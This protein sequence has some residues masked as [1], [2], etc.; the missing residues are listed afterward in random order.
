MAKTIIAYIHLDSLSPGLTGAD[1]SKTTLFV[2]CA[3][4]GQNNNKTTCQGLIDVTSR[5][6]LAFVEHCNIVIN[7]Q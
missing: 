7:H 6:I 3:V 2:C 1:D 5:H 4:T